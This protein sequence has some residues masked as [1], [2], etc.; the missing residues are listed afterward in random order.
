MKKNDSEYQAISASDLSGLE[1]RLADAAKL[2]LALELEDITLVQNIVASYFHLHQQIQEQ[3]ATITK[4][5]KI[6]GF[7]PKSERSGTK[8]KAVIRQITVTAERS[9]KCI[10]TACKRA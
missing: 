1:A 10:A 7:E 2:E 6:C 3:G 8:V 4:L 5:R 9:T